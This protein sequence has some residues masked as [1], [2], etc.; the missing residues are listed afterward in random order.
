MKQEY[1]HKLFEKISSRA[2]FA[3]SRY[4][5]HKYQVVVEFDRVQQCLHEKSLNG[6]WLKEPDI[7]QGDAT[8]LWFHFGSIVNKRVLAEVHLYFISL[9][10]VKDM[11]NV[12]TSEKDLIFIKRE[13]GELYKTLEHYT[14]GRNT[15][16][17][18]ADRIPGGKRH[19]DVKDV[20]DI[21]SGNSRKILGGL[22]G[23]I[24]K[25]GDQ[26][27]SLSA[28]NFQKIINDLNNFET[29]LHDYL[30]K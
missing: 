2:S 23:E 17:H 15:F 27:W 28:S 20:V 16:E 8:R 12:I 25:F 21:E 24:Y 30:R 29:I 13:I 6:E 19:E 22:R 10:N 18:Y 14:N 4:W 3:Y 26:E 7:S 11:L 1:E 9:D 5:L